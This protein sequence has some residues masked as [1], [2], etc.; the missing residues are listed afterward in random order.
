MA[1]FLDWVGHES[2]RSVEF[3]SPAAQKLASE[4]LLRGK[5]EMDPMRALAVVL[6]T[7][8][9]MSETSAGTII[10]RLRSGG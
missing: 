7:S 10:V 6:Q 2:G 8:D 4:T 5:V 1:E 9:L 3:A